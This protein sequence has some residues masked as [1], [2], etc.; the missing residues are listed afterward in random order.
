MKKLIL[1]LSLIVSTSAFAVTDKMYCKTSQIV[2]ADCKNIP[3]NRRT[4][5][6]KQVQGGNPVALAAAAGNLYLY[7]TISGSALKKCQVASN[8]VDM[9][10][11]SN[12]GDVAAAYFIGKDGSQLNQL[13][14][15]RVSGAVSKQACPKAD[16]KN[17]LKQLNL[18]GQQIR[19]IGGDFLYRIVPNSRSRVVGIA[20]TDRN[21]L[22]EWNDQRLIPT[23]GRNSQD[24]S[25]RWEQIGQ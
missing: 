13:F 17:M 18:Q 23:V 12:P 25:R 3:L 15:L 2:E 10:M 1:G 22:L 6:G 19:K 9:K 21:V 8:V 11:S 20:L 4:E 5:L 24:F 7:Y 16:K 14:D